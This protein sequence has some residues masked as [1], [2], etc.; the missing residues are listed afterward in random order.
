MSPL[1]TQI[2]VYPSDKVIKV[3]DGLSTK[4]KEEF[5][6]LLDL[7]EQG[8]RLPH[9]QWNDTKDLLTLTLNDK[10]KAYTITGFQINMNGRQ[11]IFFNHIAEAPIITL[12]L[13]HYQHTYK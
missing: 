1:A 12:R 6:T 9:Y 5:T 2:E 7:L 13:Y 8:I 11:C 10:N 4:A 3:I